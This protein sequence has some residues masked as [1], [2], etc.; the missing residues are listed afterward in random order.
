MFD[1]RLRIEKH[2]PRSGQCHRFLAAR[3]NSNDAKAQ[4]DSYPPFADQSTNVSEITRNVRTWMRL[5]DARVWYRGTNVACSFTNARAL[6][7]KAIID[8]PAQA[9]VTTG[10]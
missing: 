9:A 4:H 6:I 3:G 7:P 10:R 2:R 8:I 1:T 5:L